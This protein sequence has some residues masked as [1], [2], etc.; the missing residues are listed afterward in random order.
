MGTDLFQHMTHDLPAC[1]RWGGLIAHFGFQT[2]TGS[3]NVVLVGYEQKTFPC[4][5]QVNNKSLVLN[6]I[7]YSLT[8]WCRILV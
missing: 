6:T 1:G 2:N 5:Q 8:I 7:K 3:L 4:I